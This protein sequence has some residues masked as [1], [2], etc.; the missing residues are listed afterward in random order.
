MAKIVSEKQIN[1]FVKGFITEASP[2]TFPENASIEEE[3]FDLELN[4]ARSRRLGVDYETGYQLNATGLTTAVLATAR[5]S[6]HRWDFPGG[7]SSVI[8]GVVRIADKLWFL[9]LLT[10]NPSANLKNG[11]ASL[12]LT[13]LGNAEIEVAIVNNFLVIVSSQ[14]PSPILL[15]YNATTDVVTQETLSLSVRDVWGINDGL[16]IDT[17]PTT[18]SNSHKYNLRNQ[19]WSSK[20]TSTCGTDAIDCT[21][22]TIAS[23]PSNADQ[24]TLGKVGDSTSAS[25]EKYDPNKL[26]LNSIDNSAISKGSYILSAF[27]RGASRTSLSTITGLPVD[28]ELGALSTVASYASRIFYSGVVSSITGGDANSPNY[29]GYIFFSQVATSKDKLS[30]CYQEAD[31]TSPNISDII[32][33]DGGTIQIP[34]ASHI[35]KIIAA[36]SSLIVLAEN[37]VW[38]IYGDTGGFIATSFQMSKVSSVGVTNPKAVVDANGTIVYWAKSG[39]FALSQDPASGRYV[40]QNL[41]LTTIQTFYSG[42]P[43]LARE[44]ARGFY[45]EIHNHIRWVYNDSATYSETN[46]IN[47]YTKELNLD[48]ALQAFYIYSVSSLASNTPKINDYIG[49]P[50]HSLSVLADAI[51]VGTDPV[52]ITPTDSVVVNI[53]TSTARTSTYYFLTLVGTSFTLSKYSNTTFKDWVT[54]DGVGVDYLSYLVTGYELLGDVMRYKQVPYILFYFN[55]TEDGFTTVGGALEIDHPSSCLVQAQ[56]N[57]TNSAASGKWGQQ[58]QAYRLLRNYIPSGPADT[59]DYGD[60]VIVTKSRLRGSGR[61]LSLKIMSETGK[62]MKLL[63]WAMEATGDSKP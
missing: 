45:D 47:N 62:D 8:L 16:T 21:F 38:E 15:T 7:S 27:N 32:D 17:R 9:D 49:I 34:E 6:A 37:G 59:F 11:G 50:G 24:W 33:T 63:G 44:N 43:D 26:K 5:Q 13:G 4:G 51:Y 40:S 20:I 29:S 52:I 10:A 54:A 1:S 56:W 30:K 22:T 12:T 18:L 41:S 55:R 3:N 23:Y 35:V 2:L 58:F 28:R 46:Y 60:G 14:L 25:F 39:I 61:A 31:P 42:I 19:G 36:K 53:N 48:L 57:W